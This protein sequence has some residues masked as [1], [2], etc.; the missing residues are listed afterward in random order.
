MG[1]KLGGKFSRA[2][3]DYIRGGYRKEGFF[4]QFVFFHLL[5]SHS[6]SFSLILEKDKHTPTCSNSHRCEISAEYL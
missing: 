4:E 5:L 6:A 1:G 3:A 2:W